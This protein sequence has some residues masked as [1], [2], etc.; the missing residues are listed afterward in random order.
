MADIIILK[1]TILE[2]PITHNNN[3]NLFN[4]LGVDFNFAFRPYYKKRIKRGGL[5]LNL[6]QKCLVV[7]PHQ[8]S[9]LQHSLPEVGLKWRGAREQ[10]GQGT[11]GMA[12]FGAGTMAVLWEKRC[13]SGICGEVQCERGRGAQCTRTI[14]WVT[15]GVLSRLRDIKPRPAPP[16]IPPRLWGCGVEGC[17]DGAGL[18]VF[19]VPDVGTQVTLQ[20]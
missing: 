17:A 2:T 13:R 14:I 19:Q 8:P 20:T 1:T 9:L 6:P 15:F 12:S 18:S 5:I 10:W 4:Y 7:E 16:I 3:L 11:V